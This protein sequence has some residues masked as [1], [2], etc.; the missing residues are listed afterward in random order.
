MVSGLNIHS[1]KHQYPIHVVIH[2]SFTTQLNVN[3]NF[4]HFLKIKNKTIF[5]TSLNWFQICVSM[6]YLSFISNSNL[7]ITAWLA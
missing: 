4:F 7:I 3:N 5:N 6:V 2:L 1:A